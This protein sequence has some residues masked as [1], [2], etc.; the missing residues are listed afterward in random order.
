[1]MFHPVLRTSLLLLPILLGLVPAS[2][3]LA[4]G[5]PRW[6]LGFGGGAIRIPDYRGAGEAG[7]Y[8]YPFVM[9]IYRGRRFQADEEGIRGLLG[10]LP[11]LRLDLSFF[12]NVPVRGNSGARSGMDDL[13]PILEIGPMLRYKPWATADARQSIIIDAPIRAAL[14]IGSGI[15][16]VGYSVTPRVSYR[17]EVKPF[18]GLSFGGSRPW[19]WSLSGEALW[20]SR[21]LHR[22][23]YQ[24]D[25]RDATATRPAYDAQAGFG[26]TRL[27][28][29]LYRRDPDK[30]ISFYLLYDNLRGAVFEDSPLVEQRDG[31][32]IGFVVTWFLLQSADRVE[33]RPW[34]WTQD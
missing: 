16:A 3:T 34:E 1:M 31:F 8:P 10:K 5:L 14:A 33:T 29:S 25:P 17:R 24:V 20:G 27:R 9:P 7:V 13:D 4:E 11:R 30:L 6:E 19:R 2:A 18:A 32:T 15:D 26:G 28:T 23:Y 21:G 12:G 22:Y